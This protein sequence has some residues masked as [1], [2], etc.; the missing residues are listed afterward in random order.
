ML[1]NELKKNPF[2]VPDNYFDNLPSRV[3][4][5]CIMAKKRPA[6]GFIPKLAWAGGI[7]ILLLA[8]FLSYFNNF[9]NTSKE[10][11][12]PDA[13]TVGIENKDIA[14]EVAGSHENY[15]KS[16]RDAV[17]DYLAVRNVNLNDYLATKY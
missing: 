13:R 3:Q 1:N 7:T 12:N 6:F 17:V 16:R 4:D 9:S 5:R 8:L 10:Q 2:V 15:L 11:Q 14:P